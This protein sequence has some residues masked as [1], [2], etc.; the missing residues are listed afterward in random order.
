MRSHVL[1]SLGLICTALLFSETKVSDDDALNA[2]AFDM[3]LTNSKAADEKNKLEY[4]PGLFFVSEAAGYYTPG[5]GRYGSDTRFYGKAFIKAT[6]ADVGSLY[7]AGNFNYF[8]YAAANS[9]VFR[10][11]YQIQTPDPT[12]ISAQLAEFHYSFD[13]AKLVFFRVGSQLISWGPAYFWSP[14]DFI[15]RQKSLAAVVSVVDVRSGK[16]G[17]R[18]HIPLQPVNIFLFT[19][20]SSVVQDGKAMDLAETIAQGWHIDATLFGVNF[21]TT[22]YVTKNAP[23]QIGFDA[24]GNFMTADVYGELAFTLTNQGS[25]SVGAAGTVGIVK[26]FGEEQNWTVRGEFYYNDRG[27][28]DTALSSLTPGTF[29]PFYSGKYYAYAEVS[30]TKLF[31]SVL[32]VSIFGFMNIADRSYSATA[33]CSFTFPGIVPFSVFARYYGGADDREFT[34]AYGGQALQI[35]ARIRIEL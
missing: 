16:P 1:L 12:A 29:T 10:T 30:G 20:L 24:T 17:V 15:N 19:D 2:A 9:T 33:Q 31:G 5:D 21:A 35:G 32:G 6:K 4:L 23:A 26:V 3:S 34:S 7:L 8:L 18:I 11:L 14:E 13:I 22:G 27:Y 25:S 28:G